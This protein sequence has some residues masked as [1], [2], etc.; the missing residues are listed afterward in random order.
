MKT[1]NNI[2]SI[3]KEKEDSNPFDNKI[4]DGNNYISDDAKIE[5]NFEINIL[6]ESSDD[7]LS[8]EN[9]ND[10]LYVNQKII[11][12][13]IK[14]LFNFMIEVLIGCS[15]EYYKKIF[16]KYMIREDEN[17]YDFSIIYDYIPRNDMMG[18]VKINLTSN[19]FPDN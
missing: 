17:Y 18:K 19:E 11:R 3:I 15:G 10:M 4:N 6:F 5:S 9:N 7:I 13:T 12:R 1:K 2:F 14:K 16:R 8:D